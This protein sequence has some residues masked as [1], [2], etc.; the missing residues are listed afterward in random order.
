MLG[1]KE[2]IVLI[3]RQHWFT[4]VQAIL[5]EIIV[6][7]VIIGIVTAVFVFFPPVGTLSLF[8]LLLLIIPI[9]SL[10]HDALVWTNREYIVTNRR[11]IQISGVI[12]KKVTDSSLEKVNDVK[13]AQSFWG[14]LFDFGDVEILT[15]SEL[16]INK[17][18]RIGD[19]IRFKTAMLNA[20]EE[21]E[22]QTRYTPNEDRPADIPTIIGQLDKLRQQG[23]L[24]E[25]EFQA[26]KAD[27][28]KKL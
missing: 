20:K 8:G 6:S 10:T 23:I 26:K 27:L 24:S 7:L 19:P 17:F 3:T 2:K 5:T 1:D 14:R 22:R 25:T 4:L 13:M 28:L 9:V 16:G 11:V 15:A 12:N 18:Q 21:V